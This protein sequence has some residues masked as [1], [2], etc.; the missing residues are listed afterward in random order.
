MKKFYIIFIVLSAC[1]LNSAEWRKDFKNG[2]P[3]NNNFPVGW[4]SEGT[5]PGVPNSKVFVKD[6]VLRLE[7]DKS[8]GGLIITVDNVDL[9]KTPVMRWRWRAITLPEG[10]DG[11]NPSKDDQAV[12]I[13]VGLSGFMHKK[14]VA[15]HYDT[16]TPKGEWGETSYI[17]GIVKVKFL[18]LRNQD[19]KLGEWYIEERNVAEDL[20]K[21]YGEVPTKFGLSIIANSHNTK[22]KSAAEVDY[23]EFIAPNSAKK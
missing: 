23:I 16:A 7:C 14:S 13:Y 6:G 3:K 18:A 20:K 5:L 22:T 2:D 15:Y 10:A 21:F 12:G 17:M 4:E 1:L 8:S 19:D 9:K 11:R